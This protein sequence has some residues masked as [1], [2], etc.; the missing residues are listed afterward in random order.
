MVQLSYNIP[1]ICFKKG[2]ATR[3]EEKTV[4]SLLTYMTNH[5]DR[6]IDST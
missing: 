2:H 6:L 1:T 4:A 3:A 5:T